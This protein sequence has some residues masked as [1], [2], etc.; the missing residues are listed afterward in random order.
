M[1]IIGDVHGNINEYYRLIQKLK[2]KT[3]SICVGDFGFKKEH[4]WFLKNIDYTQHLINF[5]NHDYLPYIDHPHSCGR[6]SM[7]KEIMTISGAESIDKELRVE[8]KSW[9]ADEEMNYDQWKQCIE[10]YEFN[11]PKIVISHEC[12]QSIRHTLFGFHQKSITTNGLQQCFEIHQPELW[13]FGHYHESKNVVI[14]GTRF[15]CLGELET[16]EI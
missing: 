14:N 9:W 5:G 2:G 16:F 4:D 11:K 7:Y 13:I 10:H 3:S 15:I 6:Y 1:L 12:P 8:G